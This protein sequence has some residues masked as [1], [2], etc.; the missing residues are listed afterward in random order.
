MLAVG[1]VC[2][3]AGSALDNDP[4]SDLGSG[5]VDDP[6]QGDWFVV[7]VVVGGDAQGVADRRRRP[8]RTGSCSPRIRCAGSV[9]E[10]VGALAF[11]VGARLIDATVFVRWVT[12]AVLAVPE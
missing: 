10:G 2:G 1:A 3:R 8:N 5:C 12:R 7:G 9:A 11:R 4:R 6:D